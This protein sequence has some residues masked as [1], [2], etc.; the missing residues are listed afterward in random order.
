MIDYKR[1]SSRN[2]LVSHLHQL[3]GCPTRA[4]CALTAWRRAESLSTSSIAAT[5]A[6]SS[7]LGDGRGQLTVNDPSAFLRQ[8][9]QSRCDKMGQAPYFLALRISRNQLAQAH[10]M[11]ES[12]WAEIAPTPHAF[13]GSVCGPSEATQVSRLARSTT[14]RVRHC[15]LLNFCLGIRSALGRPRPCQL[16]TRR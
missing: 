11:N 8:T 2:V 12:E 13:Q 5:S 6:S 4:P 9:L 16:R 1:L 7:R 3:Y 10:C 15:P 14:M